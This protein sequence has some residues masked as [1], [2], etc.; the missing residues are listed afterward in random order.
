M[1]P[2]PSSKVPFVSF[3]KYSARGKHGHSDQ[4]R[5]I[6]QAIKG[7]R[8]HRIL[9]ADGTTTIRRVI[10]LVAERIAEALPTT[11]VLQDCFGEGTTL[12]PCPRCSPV[13]EGGLWPAFNICQVLV[14]HGLALETLPCLVRHTAVTKSQTAERGERPMPPTHYQSMAV[15]S[16]QLPFDRPTRITVVDDVITRG[17]TF[18][19]AHAHLKQTFPGVPVA[20]FAVVR[21]IKDDHSV[22]SITDPVR[23]LITY[24]VGAI[25]RD[26]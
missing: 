14:A 3:L 19:A 16:G 17:S 5:T 25:A 15:E 9:A 26:P 12:V 24:G 22:D 13:V 20:C 10:D 1:N 7:D 4:A 11:S 8:S 18:V 21:A 6:T 23:G 2:L